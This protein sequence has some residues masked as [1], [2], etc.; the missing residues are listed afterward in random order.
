MGYSSPQNLFFAGLGL[1]DLSD[2]PVRSGPA[3]NFMGPIYSQYH[4]STCAQNGQISNFIQYGHVVYHLINFLKLIDK[5]SQNIPKKYL[6]PV[7]INIYLTSVS[8]SIHNLSYTIHH[9]TL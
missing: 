1:P 5:E 3:K 7:Y 4:I 6:Q 8:M 9:R 2:L